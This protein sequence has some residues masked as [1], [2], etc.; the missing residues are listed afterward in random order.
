MPQ[1]VREDAKT[2]RMREAGL[3][4]DSQQEVA[5]PSI[6]HFLPFTRWCVTRLCR[7]V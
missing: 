2:K 5:M 4:G 3:L 1:Q 7:Q 6:P